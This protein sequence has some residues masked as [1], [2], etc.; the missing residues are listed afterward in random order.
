MNI[1]TAIN[2]KKEKLKKEF[3]R[4][5]PNKYIIN[6]L[7]ESIHR[8]QKE[9]CKKQRFRRKNWINRFKNKRH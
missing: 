3:S 4:K 7:K 2:I 9:M 8:H 1:A 6:R 5:N